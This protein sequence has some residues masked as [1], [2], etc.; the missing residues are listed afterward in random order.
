MTH[1]PH[2][3]TL[4]EGGLHAAL[5]SIYAEPGD[6]LFVRQDIREPHHLLILDA[7][8]LDS[9]NPLAGLRSGGSNRSST[10]C[11]KTPAVWCPQSGQ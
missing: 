2:I 11:G 9:A 8:L 7:S 6:D 4:N 10:C 5:K 1:D 3:G